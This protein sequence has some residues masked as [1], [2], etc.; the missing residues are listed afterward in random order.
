MPSNSWCMITDKHLRTPFDP[1]LYLTQLEIVQGRETITQKLT[2]SLELTFPAESVDDLPSIAT[3]TGPLNGKLIAKNFPIYSTCVPGTWAAPSP[4][5]IVIIIVTLDSDRGIEILVHK[6]TTAL[7]LDGPDPPPTA[8]PTDG[9]PGLIPTGTPQTAIMTNSPAPGDPIEPPNG[10]GGDSTDPSPVGGLTFPSP[11]PF[12]LTPPQGPGLSYLGETITSGS[13]ALGFVIGGQTLGSGGV[14]TDGASNV[15]SL[16]QNSTPSIAVI[17][18]SPQQLSFVTQ[19]PSLFVSGIPVPERADGAFVFN[20]QTLQ[21]G[22]TIVIAGTTISLGPG[23]TPT[24]IVVNGITSSLSSTTLPVLTLS[25]MTY[26]ASSLPGAYVFDGKTL[27]PGG[28]AITVSGNTFSLAPGGT[29]I[30]ING[31]TST[32]GATN[33]TAT[34]SNRGLPTQSPK[35]AAA[36][37]VKSQISSL[38]FLLITAV[39]LPALV[40]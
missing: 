24:N 27:A 5:M 11:T 16:D 17:N 35:S 4:T 36:G 14:I 22:G 40:A 20:D 15:V 33:A 30:V 2:Q 10:S 9:N 28:E 1:I 23:A 8:R 3:P 32:L 38:F 31:R 12:A 37:K 21:P 19:P 29:A 39:L 34:T 26:T 25:G 6:E 18:G 13:E 7:S